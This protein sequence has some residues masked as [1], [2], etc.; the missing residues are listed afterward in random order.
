MAPLVRGVPILPLVVLIVATSAATARADEPETRARLTYT[1]DPAAA[2]CP[3]ADE[4][5]AAVEARVGHAVFAEPA[6]MTIAVA[7]SRAGKAY[8]ATVA[9]PDVPG[10]RG[11]SR[12]LRSDVGCAELAT[13]AALVASIAAD[14]AAALRPPPPAEPPAP[15]A[16]R[17]WRALAGAGARGVAGLT[18]DPTLGLAVSGAA[19]SERASFGAALE[20]YA[21]S[22]TAFAPGAV[23]IRPVSLALLP[24][25]L[26]A[27]WEAC[28]VARLGLVRGSGEGYAQNLATW[29][30]FAGLGGRGAAFIDVWRVRLRASLEASAILPR[31]SFVVNESTA[32]TT[33]GVSLVLGLDALLSFQ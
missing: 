32:F 6:T 1:V 2:P 29:K 28:A 27:H 18:P 24:C 17:I 7:F 13:A 31:T 33:R 16:P 9:L 25:R 4:F 22:D 26:G 20:G 8:V 11:A 3:S 14:P 30:A 23:A 12:E 21:S 10:D 5:R 15:P 19:V